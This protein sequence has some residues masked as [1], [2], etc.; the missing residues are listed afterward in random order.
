MIDEASQ[1][2][3]YQ[4]VFLVDSN[5]S[6]WGSSYSAE[7]AANA[8]RLFALRVLV[9]FSDYRNGKRSN[10]RWGYKIF[11]SRSLSHHVERHDFKEFSIS[12]FEDF[13]NQVS[14]KLN[15]SFAQNAQDGNTLPMLSKP[16]AG[17][18]CICCA[19]TNAVH[20]F[21]WDGPDMSSP[22]RTT[23]GNVNSLCSSKKKRNVMF[24]L[25]GCPRD[26]ASIQDFGG[27]ISPALTSLESLK[28]VLMPS[29]LYKEFKERQ[30]CLQWVNIGNVQPEEVSLC[31]NCF[32]SCF[33]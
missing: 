4:V 3:C 10:I 2:N 23:R 12:V 22:V 28:N 11:T 7:N 13:E 26:D 21:Q 19:F 1:D 31:M 17:A 20:D 25:S 29:V 33:V 24:L 14:K 15:E 32:C 8:I 27:E 18:K 6:L 16:P 5:P 9:Y 30:I